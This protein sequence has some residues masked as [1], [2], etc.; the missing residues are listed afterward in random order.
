MSADDPAA[1]QLQVE[2]AVRL[3]KR[4]G[5]NCVVSFLA[6]QASL[7]QDGVEH[8]WKPHRGRAHTVRRDGIWLVYDE[9]PVTQFL[10][11]AEH[12]EY[13]QVHVD[14]PAPQSRPI[15]P[16]DAQ[17]EPEDS[18]PRRA[19]RQEPRQRATATTPAE[20][21][22][23]GTQQQ[24]QITT[25]ELLELLLSERR[26]RNR[27][28]SPQASEDEDQLIHD[29]AVGDKGNWIRLV[30]GIKIP[31]EIP[32]E[33]GWMFLYA[34]DAVKKKPPMSP[35]DWHRHA[36][37]FRFNKYC[38]FRNLAFAE[39]CDN[40]LVILCELMA[41]ATP[42]TTKRQWQA[43]YALMARCIY[44]VLL[45]SSMGG[46]HCAQKF[47]TEYEAVLASKE[48]K[49][50]FSSLVDEAM[51]EPAKPEKQAPA[52]QPQPQSAKDTAAVSMADINAR[53]EKQVRSILD[54]ERKKHK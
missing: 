7:G 37:A 22:S 39:E 50:D 53:V 14:P 46:S 13:D 20:P 19:R 3:I 47:T 10:W 23:P 8:E 35:V 6:R 24:E 29:I 11:P 17:D 31:A 49:L 21:A 52:P 51:R 42:R 43:A 15:L 45:A 48:G 30:P 32:E 12:Y 16:D 27:S 9:D 1:R 40:I 54:A 26:K 4:I 34:W 44:L 2:A 33:Q 38:S 41:T 28:P 36:M 18:P 5:R 25:A